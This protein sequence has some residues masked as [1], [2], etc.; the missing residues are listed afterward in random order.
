MTMNSDRDKVIFPRYAP[1]KYRC[2][3]CGYTPLEIW[4]F[5]WKE[6]R[7]TKATP[8]L[9]C[10]SRGGCGTFHDISQ[11]GLTEDDLCQHL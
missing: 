2:L 1:Y 7:K 9:V 10:D 6:G 4:A 5:T 11:Y 3:R 8:V